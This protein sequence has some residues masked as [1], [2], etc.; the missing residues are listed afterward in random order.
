LPDVMPA[1]LPIARIISWMNAEM[2]GEERGGSHQKNCGS[3][4][5]LL[6][7]QSEGIKREEPVVRWMYVL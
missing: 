1:I 4:M 6:E 2:E 7:N 3:R 5:R